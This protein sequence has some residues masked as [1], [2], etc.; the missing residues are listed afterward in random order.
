[1]PG[2]EGG[3]SP[4]AEQNHH[5]RRLLHGARPRA[6]VRPPRLRGLQRHPG[7]D[8]DLPCD[9][10]D[11][12]PPVRKPRDFVALGLDPTCYPIARTFSTTPAIRS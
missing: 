9:A 3:L 5:P 2:S 11:R 1:M 12:R 4:V 7:D 10:D 6:C 8:A